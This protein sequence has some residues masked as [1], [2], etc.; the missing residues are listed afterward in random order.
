MLFKK[1]NDK[2]INYN[3][4]ILFF[5]NTNNIIMKNN[6]YANG[7]IDPVNYV[8]FDSHKSLVL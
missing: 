1:N 2:T 4:Y 8:K 7:S 3:Y 6:M 5:S